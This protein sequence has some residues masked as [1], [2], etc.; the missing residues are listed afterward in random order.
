MMGAGTGDTVRTLEHEGQTWRMERILVCE[1]RM[2]G[3]MVGVILT[4]KHIGDL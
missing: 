1:M 3:C 2:P 4:E